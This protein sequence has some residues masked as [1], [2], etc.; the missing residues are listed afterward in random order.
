LEELR[1]RTIAGDLQKIKMRRSNKKNATPLKKTSILYLYFIGI[2]NL[3]RE[4]FGMDVQ[5]I[6]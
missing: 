4:T 5:T 6:L 3:V 1:F 2:S